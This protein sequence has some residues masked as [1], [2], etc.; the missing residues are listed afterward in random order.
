MLF[1]PIKN[2]HSPK[3]LLPFPSG[4]VWLVVPALCNTPHLHSH[5][6]RGPRVCQVGGQKEL[7]WEKKAIVLISGEA[8]TFLLDNYLISWIFE[9]CLSTVVKYIDSPTCCIC[10]PWENYFGDS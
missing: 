5:F 6:S 3:Q 9:F 7:G 4:D 1:G 10:G 8:I 2:S